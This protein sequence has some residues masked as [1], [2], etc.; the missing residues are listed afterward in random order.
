MQRNVATV[1][2][3]GDDRRVGRR[4]TDTALFHL[5]HQA[6]FGITRRRLG[7][8]LGRV[9]L[10]Q[11]QRVAL[12]H[13][14]Q[15]I[16]I[17]RL[18]DL[19]HHTGV[20]VELEDTALGTQLEVACAHADGSRQVLRRQHLASQELAPDQLVEALSVALHA[21]QLGRRGVGVRRT[22]RFV[23]LLCAFLAAVDV[24]LLRQVGLA[25]FVFNISTRHRHRVLRQVGGVRT[26]IGDVASLVQT[27]G[28]H[29]GLL[30]PEAQAVARGLL[31]GGGDERRRRLAAGRFVFTLDDAVAGSLE[32][33]QRG[34]G[35]GFVQ[36]FEG[37]AFLTGH[38]KAHVGALGSA[39]VGVDF[40]VFFRDERTDLALTL[41]H[42][43]DRYR[44]HT[45]GGQATGD[46]RPQQW[47]D[48][49]ADDAVE[50]ATGLLGVDTVNVQ[51]ARLGE[52]FLN[53]FLGDFVEHHA[54]VAAVITAD[55]FAQVPGNGFPFAVQVRREIDGVSIFGEPAQLFD[56]LFLARKDFVL[57]LPAMVRV[58]THA[59]NQLLARF[60]FRREYRTFAR[61]GLAALGGRLLAG[62]SRTA[63]GQVSDMADTRLHHVLV[64]QVLVDGLGLSRGFHNDQ[65][66]AHGSE[67]S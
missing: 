13:V 59:R 36:R 38:F 22:N 44:L 37:L 51:L 64:A 20:A 32:L 67:N 23:S 35:L 54:L 49:V 25:E 5:F 1:L 12:G 6:G 3:G 9:E 16:I 62:A 10:D 4:T 19:R 48:H 53:G 55:G 2:D 27:L 28:H 56:D 7:E 31:Q 41:N 57:G 47:R 66:F 34:H 29:H 46:L 39:E 17:A 15:H 63:G 30:H 8:V 58:H 11:L 61:G 14:R 60:F 43:L 40:P 52:G 18:G 65:R 42:Q 21:A 50:E 24:W 45:A 33:L 26:H